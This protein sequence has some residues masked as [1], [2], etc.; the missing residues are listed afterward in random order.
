VI[1]CLKNTE[2]RKMFN[3][4]SSLLDE[5]ITETNN[6]LLDIFNM[7]NN[8]TTYFKYQ[9]TKSENKIKYQLTI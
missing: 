3:N 4:Q 9:S 1:N 5:E 8:H 6:I 7:N 2:V